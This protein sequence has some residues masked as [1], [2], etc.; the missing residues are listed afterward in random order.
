[1]SG[2][3]RAVAVLAAAALVSATW[4]GPRDAD[5][6]WTDGVTTSAT[7]SARTVPAPTGLWCPA[8]GLF[9]ASINWTAVPG[10]TRYDVYVG[11][12]YQGSTTGTSYGAGF[13]LSN[14]TYTVVTVMNGWPSATTSRVTVTV[15]LLLVSCSATA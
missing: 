11:S 1:M 8:L 5:A 6:A 12:T 10:A 4:S 7:L 2:R 3:R 14:T 9:S 15:V 13:L